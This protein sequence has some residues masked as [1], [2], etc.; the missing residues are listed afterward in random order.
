MINDF[1]KLADVSIIERG[2]IISILGCQRRI[3]L[4]TEIWHVDGSKKWFPAEPGNN[5]TW[6]RGEND[7]NYRI[8]AREVEVTKDSEMMYKKYHDKDGDVGGVEDGV[9]VDD[10]YRQ[11]ILSDITDLF[12]KVEV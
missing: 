2:S 7:K 10:C 4:V 3:F 8:A 6:V 9:N 12:G 11:L 1:D 5:P